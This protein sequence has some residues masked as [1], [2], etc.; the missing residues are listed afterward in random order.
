[1][2]KWYHGW[3]RYPRTQQ[4]RREAEDKHNPY[5]RAKRRA[6]NLPTAY[7]DIFVRKQKS[8]K[9]RRK[10]RYHVKTKP[11]AWR[12]HEFNGFRWGDRSYR[13]LMLQLEKRG[14]FHYIS[15][16][17]SWFCKRGYPQYTTVVHWYGPEIFKSDDIIHVDFD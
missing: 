2:Q 3:L 12:S 16:E 6:V 5:V 15:T 11:Y 4:E 1:M 9:S 8:W 7:E 10:T 17:D 14:F 13:K